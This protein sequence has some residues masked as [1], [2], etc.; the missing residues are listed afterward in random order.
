[1]LAGADFVAAQE[2]FDL[3]AHP[4]LQAAQAAMAAIRAAN[5]RWQQPDTCP[6]WVY[7]SVGAQA[8][9]GWAATARSAAG[10]ASAAGHRTGRPPPCWR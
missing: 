8:H 1:M 10:R 6:S 7:W 2:P 5:E 4:D 9:P 3:A